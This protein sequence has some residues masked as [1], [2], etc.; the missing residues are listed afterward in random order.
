[1]LAAHTKSDNKDKYVHGSTPTSDVYDEQAIVAARLLLSGRF[2]DASLQGQLGREILARGL[3]L[4]TE[5]TG[6]SI[7]CV[8]FDHDE[9]YQDVFNTEHLNAGMFH[10]SDDEELLFVFSEQMQ[11]GVFVSLE[12]STTDPT[13]QYRLLRSAAPNR[14]AFLQTLYGKETKLYGGKNS[15]VEKLAQQKT[16]DEFAEAFTSFGTAGVRVEQ[17]TKLVVAR[18]RDACRRDP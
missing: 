15:F 9:V 4:V 16:M 11:H 8:S 13:G 12:S 1:M 14:Q 18:A 7:Y 17:P 6:Q 5:A 3:E 10:G 2:S